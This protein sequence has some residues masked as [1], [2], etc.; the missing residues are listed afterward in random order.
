MNASQ[1][2]VLQTVYRRLKP[3]A[4]SLCSR[5]LWYRPQIHCNK[6]WLGNEG[7]RWCVCPE[8][9]TDSSIVYSFGVGKDLSFDL[10]IVRR[11]KAE[12][13]AFDP[14]PGSIEWVGNQVLPRQIVFH[15]YG[16]ASFD[17]N[18]EFLPP[19]NPMHISHTMIPKKEIPWPKITVPVRRLAT[20]MA[21]L[22]HERID[23]LKM[24]I[25]GAEYT[26]LADILRNGIQVRQLLVE[27]HHRW[28]EIGWK[29]TKKALLELNG[30]G[31]RIFSISTSGEEYSFLHVGPSQAQAR[32]R[33]CF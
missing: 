14:T 17:G 18:S 6:I 21:N 24:D 16:I 25:E 26:V 23:L 7:A 13:H 33:S 27:F 9:V 11:F 3:L 12:L 19:R 32:R 8:E 1:S 5:R 28:P 29:L 31:F 20:I 15:K 2:S 22:G 30:A 4:Q 10:E